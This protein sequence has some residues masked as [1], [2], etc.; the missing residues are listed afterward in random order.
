MRALVYDRYGPPEVLAIRDLPVPRPG[1]GEVLV[2]VRAAALNPK[3]VL[4]R[5]GR[6][7]WI[8]GSRFPKVM[9]LD[10]AGEVAALG[11][12]ARGPA[13][14]ARVFG[15]VNHWRALRGTMA[16]YV[17]LPARAL[18]PMPA[19]AAF[20]EA[21]ALP[22]AGCTSLQALRDVARVRPGDRVLLNGAAGGVGTVAI[23]LAKALGA[24]VTT[25]SGAASR[26]ACLALGADEALDYA[27]DAPFSGAR[28]FRVILDVF[29]NRSLDAARPAL[30]RD[31]VYV[32]TV[33]SRRI[34]VDAA[35]TL[36][37]G[38]RARL[39]VVRP[40]TPDLVLLA[41]LVEEGRL[42]AVLDGVLPLERF[43]EAVRRLETRHAHGKIV[44]TLG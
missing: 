32:T 35:R 6:F 43:L 28:T 33:P 36:A 22:I 11:P 25:T 14:G 19:G 26:A 13:P 1:R 44:L 15:A 20:A 8:S 37:S 2:R 40:R 10:V 39:V 16:E 29:G 30:A 21:A 31:G 34:L 17:S 3:D 5:K 24:H 18:A 27:A 12:G 41:R 7:R 4:L 23:Q 9:G 38:P 42:R